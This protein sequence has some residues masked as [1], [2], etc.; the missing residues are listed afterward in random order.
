MARRGIDVSKVSHEIHAK[1]RAERSI[2]W[3]TKAFAEQVKTHLTEVVWP[4]STGSILGAGHP[5]ETGDFIDSVKI[6]QERRP[7]GSRLGG[8]F[9]AGYEIYSDHPN[10]N[11]IENGSGPDKPG[12][13]S[14]WGPNTPTP[15][16]APFART[17]HHF[18][19]TSP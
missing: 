13:K 16:Y 11:F 6:R 10:A 19:G 14:P 4:S 5:Y 7:K 12:S 18:G 2:K 17:A 8:Q 15:E 1:I 3:R 9:M